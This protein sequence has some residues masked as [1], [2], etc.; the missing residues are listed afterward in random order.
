MTTDRTLLRSV[1]SVDILDSLAQ[2]FCFVSQKLLQLFPTPSH[3][4]RVEGLSKSFLR[5]NG[6]LLKYK[7]IIRQIYDSLRDAV[8]GV[9][10]KA[11][12][13]STEFAKQT[14]SR[15]CAFG[16]KSV[17]QIRIFAFDSSNVF[18]I[19]KTVVRQNSDV[20][21]SPINPQDFVPLG[22][23]SR[24]NFEHCYDIPLI[25]RSFVLKLTC[26]LHRGPEALNEGVTDKGDFDSAGGSREFDCLSCA[27]TRVPVK[28]NGRES[29][30]LRLFGIPLPLCPAF[31][32]LQY[33]DRSGSGG[34]NKLG[35]EIWEPLSERKIGSTMEFGS[36]CKFLLESYFETVLDALFVNRECVGENSLLF[37]SRV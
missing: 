7:N 19:D 4:P 25:L 17:S 13:L 8:I 22:L 18:R 12:F 16:L 27:G 21:D 9:L 34:A 15:F 5:S 28:P 11:V 30:W 37:L 3:Q 31:D 33:F 32:C 6:K 14:F 23:G 35:R 2:Q 29:M 10:D 36:R 1:A 26:G 20:F 24:L